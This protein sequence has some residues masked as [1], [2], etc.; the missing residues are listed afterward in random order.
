MSIP[1]EA[2]QL[3]TPAGRRAWAIWAARGGTVGGFLAEVW[4]ARDAFSHGL[5]R[6][7]RYH[8]ERKER[9][10]PLDAEQVGAQG[11]W[12]AARR[13]MIAGD[14]VIVLIPLDSLVIA[15]AAED[16]IAG[17]RLTGPPA[18]FVRHCVLLVHAFRERPDQVTAAD[19]VEIYGLIAR[20]YRGQGRI[21]QYRGMA[22]RVP[23]II[24]RRGGQVN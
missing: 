1:E 12:E 8:R 9:A 10:R 24:D 7:M 16:M 15:C 11:A 21:E 3:D 17:R 19:A 14:T 5:D 6:L 2:A 13:A 18:Y 4:R 22:G 20:I 23:S